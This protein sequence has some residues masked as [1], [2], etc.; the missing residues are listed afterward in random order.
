MLKKVV[1]ATL[2][3]LVYGSAAADV[4]LS[5]R[6]LGFALA[7]P[8]LS[9]FRARGFTRDVSTASVACRDCPA[10]VRELKR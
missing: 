3:G 8:A 6:R 4:G 9:Y 2:V 10:T 5:L 7:A 1:V